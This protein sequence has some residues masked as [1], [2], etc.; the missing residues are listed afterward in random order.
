M[1]RRE[2]ERIEKNKNEKGEEVCKHVGRRR[3]E[4]SRV[5]RLREIFGDV[6]EV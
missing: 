4:E 5:E 2:E 3:K 1:G 6:Y